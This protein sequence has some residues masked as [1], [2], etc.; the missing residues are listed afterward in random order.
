MV[1]FP[2]LP[3]TAT[4]P[5]AL[6]ARGAA[7]GH[8]RSQGIAHH[9]QRRIRRNAFGDRTDQCRARAFFQR[10]RYKVMAVAV[11]ALQRHEKIA[12]RNRARV[13][14][15]AVHIPCALR[16]ATGRLRHLVRCP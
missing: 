15:D 5:A 8:Q 10:R 16:D 6:R 13:D 4:I 14:G 9:Q 11:I 7:H 12:R 1:V 3:V 2:A